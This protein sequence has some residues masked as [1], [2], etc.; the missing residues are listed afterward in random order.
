MLPISGSARSEGAHASSNGG[1]PPDYWAKRIVDRLITVGDAA[2]EPI[3]AQALRLSRAACFR[4]CSVGLS[5]RS[6]VIAPIG[7]EK[8][9]SIM[10]FTGSKHCLYQLQV[11][12]SS[13]ACMTSPPRPAKRFQDRAVHQ[14]IATLTRGGPPPT[15]RPAR[16]SGTGYTATGSWSSPASRPRGQRHD[17]RLQ[18]SAPDALWT[19]SSFT[20]RGALIYNTTPDERPPARRSSFSIL[21]PTRLVQRWRFHGYLPGSRRF[22]R[23]HPHRL[24]EARPWPTGTS[25][26]VRPAPEQVLTGPMRSP[27]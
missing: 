1:L 3:R 18:I 16:P 27:P 19:T 12:T 4:S 9:T 2:P 15:R 6:R 8:E 13:R 14:Q 11:L 24:N 21:A 20:A 25:G 22:Q 7:S 26:R 17:R 10:A 5:R 23:D